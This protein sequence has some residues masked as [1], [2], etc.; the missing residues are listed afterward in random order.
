MLA[1]EQ[2]KEATA[3]LTKQSHKTNQAMI[4]LR[5]EIDRAGSTARPAVNRARFNKPMHVMEHAR[6][7]F[8]H[9]S[10]R[11]ITAIE[12]KQQ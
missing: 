8:A 12:D 2:F 11:S 5:H 10:E 4:T 1:C 6:Q 7:L 9:F 3:A